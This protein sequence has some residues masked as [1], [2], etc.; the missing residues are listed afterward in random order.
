MDNNVRKSVCIAY[1]TFID[2]TRDKDIRAKMVVMTL[3]H[4]E[5]GDG[6]GHVYKIIQKI[7]VTNKTIGESLGKN[8]RYF[9]QIIN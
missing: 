7:D 8:S 6:D 5:V 3:G 2:V 4:D 1:D 9:A